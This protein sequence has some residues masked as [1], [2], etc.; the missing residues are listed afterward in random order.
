M[1]EWRNPNKVETYTQ[2]YLYLL[3]SY[4]G[5][6]GRQDFARGFFFGQIPLLFFSWFGTLI[7]LLLIP[8][9]N[10]NDA[11]FMCFVVWTIFIVIVNIIPFVFLP[12][13]RLMDMGYGE[14]ARAGIIIV[15]YLFIIV[16]GLG[17][18]LLFLICLSVGEMKLGNPNG[19]PCTIFDDIK[20]KRD[21]LLN[22]AKSCLG[23]NDFEGAIRNYDELGD[24]QLV[25]KTMKSHLS[26]NY[27]LLKVQVSRMVDKNVRCEDLVKKTNDLAVS[28][29]TYLGFSESASKNQ[30]DKSFSKSESIIVLKNE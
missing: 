9:W 21:N 1:F 3:F 23:R 22:A 20:R 17:P 4:N 5:R 24:K 26:Y 28:V 14:D 6:I 2:Y 15:C 8:Q 30:E 7:L 16:F 25:L 27:D 13:K 18:L 19:R 10:D 29:N 11:V 12:T